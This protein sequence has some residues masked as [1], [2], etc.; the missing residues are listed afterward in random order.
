MCQ[1]LH[2]C[3]TF[4]GREGSGEQL[5]IAPNMGFVQAVMTQRDSA[6]VLSQLAVTTCG[7]MAVLCFCIEYALI[8]LAIRLIKPPLPRDCMLAVPSTGLAG[9]W[10][11]PAHRMMHARKLPLGSFQC[12]SRTAL[13]AC[14]A[15]VCVQGVVWSLST[16]IAAARMSA[17]WSGCDSRI[18]D[19][20]V[21][22]GT[23]CRPQSVRGHKC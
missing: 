10:A 5:G 9:S 13:Y 8:L 1:L 15:C 20:T 11:L 3:F 22:L 23:G 16:R 2:A 14:W 17:G 21:L 6:A 7:P 19:A 18:A 12:V 4:V